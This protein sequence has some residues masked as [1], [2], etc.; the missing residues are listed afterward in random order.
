MADEKISVLPDAATLIGPEKIAGVQSGGNVKITP[1]QIKTFVGAGVTLPLP[2]F[3]GATP[4]WVRPVLNI[5]G[6]S[7]AF[8]TWLNKASPVNLASLMNGGPGG[9]QA[10][11]MGSGYVPSDTITLAGGTPSIATVLTLNSTQLAT[12]TIVAPGT[13]GTPGPAIVAGTTGVNTTGLFFALNVTVNGAGAISSIDSV[14]YRSD[15]TTNPTDLTAEPLD[16]AGLTGATVLI[17]MGA[18]AATVTTP[19]AYSAYPPNPVSQG[20]SSGSGTGSKWMVS[21]AGKDAVA[22]DGTSG[23]PLV[24]QFDGV[25]GSAN[26]VGLTALLTPSVSPPYTIKSAVAV[27]ET[28]SAGITI[29]PIVLYNSATKKAVALGW[30]P[31]GSIYVNHYNNVSGSDFYSPI[32]AGGG[33]VPP[34]YFGWFSVTND[35]TNLIFSYSAENIVFLELYREPLAAFSPTFD[36]CGFG[37]DRGAGPSPILVALWNWLQ[38]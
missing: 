32:E 24:L 28:S 14:A 13:G 34:G 10:A 27:V 20:S 17:T 16:G 29:S 25:D 22:T 12:A 11:V 9:K 35:G 7:S 23:A 19:G 15:Y 4:P 30:A 26:A 3:G 37:S 18:S 38:S 1:D 2:F 36:L 5:G 33:Q 21:Y 6:P 31:N 8:N